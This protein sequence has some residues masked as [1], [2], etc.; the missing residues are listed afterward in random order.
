[1]NS[2][3]NLKSWMDTFNLQE[4]GDGPIPTLNKEGMM[5]SLIDEMGLEC[6]VVSPFTDNAL[7]TILPCRVTRWAFHTCQLQTWLIS[8]KIES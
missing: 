6:T 8:S 3:L 5:H 2:P 4:S 7:L 1:M